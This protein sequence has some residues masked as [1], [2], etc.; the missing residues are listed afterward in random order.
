[1][2][3]FRTSDSGISTNFKNMYG[4]KLASNVDKD[5]FVAGN[6][7]FWNNASDQ[8]KTAFQ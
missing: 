7:A 4:F 1:M 8:L 5:A 2:I 3:T 6:D